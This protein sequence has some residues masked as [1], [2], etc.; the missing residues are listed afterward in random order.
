MFVCCLAQLDPDLDLPCRHSHHLNNISIAIFYYY[1]N[2][3]CSLK[4][5]YTVLTLLFPIVAHL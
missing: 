3:M 5:S 1:F 2:A 4:G